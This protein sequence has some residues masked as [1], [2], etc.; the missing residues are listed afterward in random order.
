MAAPVFDYGLGFCQGIKFEIL[1]IL[2]REGSRKMRGILENLKEPP[3]ER[4]L[5]DDLAALRSEG[6]VAS[7]GHARGAVWFLMSKSK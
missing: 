1:N 3:P 2:S 5:R 7:K 6:I 4:T